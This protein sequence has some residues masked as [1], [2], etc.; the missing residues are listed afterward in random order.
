[1]WTAKITIEISNLT[2][3]ASKEAKQKTTIANE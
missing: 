1:M 2:L 3:A